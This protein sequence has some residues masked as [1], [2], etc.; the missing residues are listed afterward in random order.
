M[1]GAP[2]KKIIHPKDQ[3]NFEDKAING[4]H[5]EWTHFI[6]VEA[7]IEGKILDIQEQFERSTMDIKLLASHRKA[8]ATAIRGLL[9]GEQT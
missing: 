3:Y 8:I 4:H 6:R 5:D 1:S 2:K 9:T 7:D